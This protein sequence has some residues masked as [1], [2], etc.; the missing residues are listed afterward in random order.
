MPEAA[1]PERSIPAAPVPF[2]LGYAPELDGLRGVAI[3]AVMVY[4]AY[5]PWLRGGLIGVDI[6]FAL[7]GYLITAL[8]IQEFDATGQIR[9]KAFYLRR[10]LRLFPALLLLL[11]IFCLASVLILGISGARTQLTDAL[12]ALFYSTN[13]A[14]A[15]RLHP[16]YFL[17]HTWS[18]SIEEQFYL[19]WPPLLLLLLRHSR[20][21]WTSVRVPLAI[22]LCAWALRSYL[23]LTG[24]TI[25][26]L[27]NGLDT[28]ADSLMVGCVLGIIVASNLIPPSLQKSI[29]RFCY[30]ASPCSLLLLLAISVVSGWRDPL[31]YYAWLFLIPI[32]TGI[33]IL[34]CRLNPASL[35]KRFLSLKGLVWVGT[36][37]YGLYLWHYPIY[38]AMWRSGYGWIEVTTLGT[39]ITFFV[40]TASYRFLEQPFLRWK[41]KLAVG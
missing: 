27:S 8:L 23:G 12:I 19:L 16:P 37:S 30:F 26:R 21:R 40:T 28:R 25:M 14:R 18:L 5:E 3:A 29:A 6:F 22:A 32:L 24:A 13:W 33:I 36:I 17:G 34:D 15:L 11:L 1:G 20:S 2:R 39:V 7:S 9:L 41:K 10:V 38:T 4:H 35:V 31:M